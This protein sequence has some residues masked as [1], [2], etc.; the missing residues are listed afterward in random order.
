VVLRQLRSV[1]SWA[2][3]AAVVCL[4]TVVGGAAATALLWIDEQRAERLRE[5]EHAVAIERAVVT[6]L[7]KYTTAFAG[8][9]ALVA[10]ADR[11]D[12][13]AFAVF[14]R[15]II[16]ATGLPAVAY[17]EVVDA[18]DRDDWER[19]NGTTIRE[20]TEQ[21]F[22]DAG[23]R[24]EYWPVTMVAPV[25]D[26]TLAIVGFDVSVQP[27]RSKAVEAALATGQATMSA[28]ILTQPTEEV[29]VYFAHPLIRG[30][31]GTAR[32]VGFLTTATQGGVLGPRIEAATARGSSFTLIDAETGTPFA[33]S[34]REIDDVEQV[35]RFEIAGRT[36][37]LETADGGSARHIGSAIA[38]GGTL[39][40]LVLTFVVG[41]SAQQLRRDRADLQESEH[42]VIAA[43]QGRMVVQRP[44]HMFGWEVNVSYRPAHEEIGLG[45]DW[46]DVVNHSDGSV[47]IVVGDV[48]GHGVD[49]VADMLEL[50]SSLRSLIAAG[51]PMDTAL[52]FADE[53]LQ[54][55]SELR[56][57]TAAVVTLTDDT[58]S[59]SLAG[60]LPPL[61]VSPDSV[62]QLAAANGGILGVGLP[63]PRTVASVSFPAECAV[64]VYSDGLV[65][66]P[67]RSID[68]SIDDLGAVLRASF[69]RG[70]DNMLDAALAGALGNDDC[71]CVI[72]RRSARLV[73]AVGDRVGGSGSESTAPG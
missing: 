40:A 21:G 24:A 57:A 15:E 37:L 62:T 4:M 5:N 58:V 50:R 33:W 70:F 39:A 51:S 68:D 1:P 22:V 72:A 36:V 9:S 46:Y 17:N 27:E 47:T 11:V 56:T 23:V 60:H 25:D 45:G 43:L 30:Q 19:R 32:A 44:E 2:S 28:P 71:V 18:D 67:S 73:S 48:A 14:S 6:E 41:R 69:G 38:L 49:A 34:E 55:S 3:V 31:D 63:R 7:T 66:R 42:R 10:S 65:E 8:A 12:P 54:S 35:R 13:D 16:D 29:G 61:L 59:W 26:G 64:V 53:L 20:L 52:R